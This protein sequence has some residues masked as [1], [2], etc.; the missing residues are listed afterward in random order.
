MTRYEWSNIVLSADGPESPTVRLV[1]VALLTFVNERTGCAW[2]A[3]ETIAERSGHKSL[4]TVQAALEEAESE[5]WL[6]RTTVPGHATR[7][8]P[9]LPGDGPVVDLTPAKIA[10]V[11]SAPRP[12]QETTTTPA[13]S[14][15]ESWRE[16]GDEPRKDRPPSCPLCSGPMK[17][18]KSRKTKEPLF[19]GCSLYD[20][21]KG[22]MG[23]REL[24]WDKPA[25]TAAPSAQATATFIEREREHRRKV[26]A[27]RAMAPVTDAIGMAERLLRK[28]K[29]ATVT[30]GDRGARAS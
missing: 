16:S 9:S 17:I 2:P 6:R 11:Q 19:W 24:D 15:G 20:K 10:G 18:Q 26:A 14:A 3:V 25:T 23:K 8:F 12:P 1:L 28:P 4:R 27:E 29:G 22:C 5:G 21:G 30:S 7:Y 13:E